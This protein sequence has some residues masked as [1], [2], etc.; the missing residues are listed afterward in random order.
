MLTGKLVRVKMS[1][2][3]VTPLY[4]DT[5]SA[6]WIEVAERLLEI[7]RSREGVTHGELEADF[8]DLF[9]DDPSQ[10][11]HQGLAKLCEDRCEFEV[12]ADVPPEQLR[13]AVFK[14]AAEVRRDLSRAWDRDAIVA[15]AAE[16]LGL[17]PER[18]E[19]TLFADLYTD[20][21]HFNSV[22]QR[23]IDDPRSLW[24]DA[25]GGGYFAAGV[26]WYSTLFGR[27]STIAAL[28]VLA[29]VK[30]HNKPVSEI[31][32]RFE[33]LPQIL[34]NV[35]FKA[36]K[37][38]E[39]AGVKSAIASAEKKLGQGGRLLVRPSGTEPLIRVMGEGDDRLLVEA[40]VD[41]VIEALTKVAA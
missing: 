12:A 4:L 8:K 35:R 27:D 9:G 15:A 30:R 25:D 29:V 22:L 40:A 13:A 36:G 19:A 31:C 6:D 26:P 33:P 23:C 21:G 41:D 32:H 3:K 24:T 28:Q 38:L 14:K 7:Y 1:R 10:L 39:N 20:N 2:N 11:I 16:D 34:K 18:V 5:H 37:P 17:S